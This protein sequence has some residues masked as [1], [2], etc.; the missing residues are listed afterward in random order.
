MVIS[1]SQIPTLKGK[2]SPKSAAWKCLFFKNIFIWFF[3]SFKDV[4]SSFSLWRRQSKRGVFFAGSF[5]RTSSSLRLGWQSEVCGCRRQ[6]GERE[7]A[8][9]GPPCSPGGASTMRSCRSKISVWFPS[10]IVSS[11]AASAPLSSSF[12][13]LASGGVVSSLHSLSFLLFSSCFSPSFFTHDWFDSLLLFSHHG[14][15]VVTV[16]NRHPCLFF[17]YIYPDLKCWWTKLSVGLAPVPTTWRCRKKS[18]INITD[19][20]STSLYKQFSTARSVRNGAKC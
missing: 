12:P 20:L 2:F 15:S 14:A 17:F 1:E 19:N 3:F 13:S 16:E 11:Y 18:S 5:K 9:K 6:P 4:T 8:G 10:Y 7:E